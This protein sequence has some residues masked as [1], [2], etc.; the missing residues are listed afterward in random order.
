M[1][2][3]QNQPQILNYDKCQKMTYMYIMC[4]PALLP[5][6]KNLDTFSV[7]RRHVRQILWA[8]S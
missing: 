8:V 1:V 5:V 3:E 7:Y 6:S 4:F 2:P